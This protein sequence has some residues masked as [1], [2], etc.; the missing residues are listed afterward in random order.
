MGATSD[1]YEI[2]TSGVTYTIA[3]DFVNNSHHQ[4]VKIVFG[5]TGDVVNNISSDTPLPV[6]TVS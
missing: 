1:N 3:S 5:N 6:G 4:I 2:I